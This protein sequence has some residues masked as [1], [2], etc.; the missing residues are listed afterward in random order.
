MKKV[1]VFF[2]KILIVFGFY[3][4]YQSIVQKNKII[5]V[6]SFENLTVKSGHFFHSTFSSPSQGE[7]PFCVY[8]PPSWKSEDTI[9]YPLLIYLYGQNGN[10]YAFSNNVAA[11]QIDKWIHNNE[12]AP[13]VLLSFLGNPIKKDIQWF[14]TKNEILLTS[15][16]SGE[17]RDF[18]QNTFRA[19]MND[20][21]ISLEGHSRGA[22]GALFYAFNHPNRFA[23]FIA[24]AY[25]SD[26]TLEDLKEAVK[27]NKPQIEKVNLKLKL[28]IGSKD[29]FLKKYDRNGSELIHQFLISQNIPHEYEILEGANHW[30]RDFWNF[31]RTHTNSVN[32][33][34]HLKYHQSSQ[35]N[36]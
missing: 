2:I 11:Q 12:I 31:K 32:G 17:L 22:T 29:L 14:S 16:A 10:E 34:L 8:L 21:L 33:N 25:V 26:Y 36:K 35:K 5:H 6:D 13:F 9:T 27:N 7:I 18:C 23:S 24:N 15:N 30:Y 28:E 19:G 1:F 3:F 4:T 20:N